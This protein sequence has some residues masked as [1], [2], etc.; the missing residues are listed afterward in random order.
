RL[1]LL[2]RFAERESLGLREDVR[3]QNVV[4]PAERVQRLCEGD[5]VTRD[6]SGSLVNQLVERMLTVG[7]WFA[8]VNRA[9][10]IG[11]IG[12]AQRDVLAVALHRQL[13]EIRGESLQVLIVGQYGNGFRAEKICVPDRQEAEQHRQIALERRRAE[14]PVH[15]MKTSQHR[16]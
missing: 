4:M 16:A 3:K 6:E 8:P 14:V 2:A 7:S 9:G 12:P 15:F 1:D 11:H 13:L 10:L 5:E